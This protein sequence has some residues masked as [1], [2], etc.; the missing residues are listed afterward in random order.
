MNEPATGSPIRLDE[1]SLL[2][3]PRTGTTHLHNLLAQ[4]AS[5]RSLPYWESLEPI[6]TKAVREGCDADARRKR[7]EG[8]L[9]L[10]HFVM[11][12]FPAMHEMTVDAPREEIQVLAADFRT[13]F[14]EAGGYVPGY[15]AWY[16]EHDQTGAYRTLK[17]EL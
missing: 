10:Q 17:L 16:R 7:C 15:G 4:H 12:L 1:T 14:F 5:L 8:A 9:R 13:M 6:P 11:P 3:L 2:G